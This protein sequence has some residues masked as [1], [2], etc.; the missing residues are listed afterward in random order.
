MFIGMA[1]QY[2]RH[3]SRAGPQASETRAR[4]GVVQTAQRARLSYAG[5]GERAFAAAIIYGTI[6]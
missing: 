1:R 6:A 5:L 2:F 3:G 4:V